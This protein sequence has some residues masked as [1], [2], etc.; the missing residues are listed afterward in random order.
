M[1]QDKSFPLDINVLQPEADQAVEQSGKEPNGS[2]VAAPPLNQLFSYLWSV[3]T[4]GV[5]LTD[6][7]S[8]RFI[9]WCAQ[10]HSM[11]A[12]QCAMDAVGPLI[13]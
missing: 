9:R 12:Q 8:Q 3:F 5:S 6:P 13:D 1:L 11:T 7:G 4:W 2:Q 10:P